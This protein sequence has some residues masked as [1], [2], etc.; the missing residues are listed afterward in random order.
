[1]NQQYQQINVAFPSWTDAET[2]AVAHI[3]PLFEEARAREWID[4]WWFIRKSP[5]WP[6]RYLLTDS[7]TE[8]RNHV[9]GRLAQL[10]SIGRILSAT[11]VVYEP[12]LH[13]FG[14]TEAMDSAHQLF[15]HDSR[16]LLAHLATIGHRPEG[17]HRRELAILLCTALIRAAGQDWYEQGDIWARVAAHREPALPRLDQ[18]DKVRRLMSVDLSTLCRPGAALAEHAE[19]AHAFTTNGRQLA[20]LAHNGQLDRGLRAVLA[21][22]IIFTWNRHGLPHTTQAAL[23]STAT[24]AVFGHDPQQQ[25]SSAEASTHLPDKHHSE[26][27]TPGP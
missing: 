21:H 23:A 20:E 18:L 22:H 10:V 16:H 24:T 4:W 17:N 9:L 13:A 3:A 12:E 11:P 26:R 15:H 2:V 19:W 7:G 6:I 25:P 27:P 8:A 5:C 14:G 1:M